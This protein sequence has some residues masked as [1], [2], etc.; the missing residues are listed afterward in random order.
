MNANPRSKSVAQHTAF[1]KH[2]VIRLRACSRFWV[3][4]EDRGP[5]KPL[6]VA[7]RE[8]RS[9]APIPPIESTVA[10]LAVHI[11]DGHGPCHGG[12]LQQQCLSGDCSRTCRCRAGT[13]LGSLAIPGGGAHGSGALLGRSAIECKVAG[14]PGATPAPLN[15]CRPAD[16][17][18]NCARVRRSGSSPLHTASVLPQ[19]A[20]C[21]ERSLGL[22]T[23]RSPPSEQNKPSILL[24]ST[25]ASLDVGLP[26]SL[27]P[28]SLFP[29]PSLQIRGQ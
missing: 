7:L 9:E 23:Q 20:A 27:P 29:P 1:Q 19:P 15:A 14:E 26:L 2:T 17:S 13:V 11:C 3:C 12:H 4:F 16:S 24:G 21:S 6:G 22:H 28:L 18:T 25:G 5:P 8:K 10:L